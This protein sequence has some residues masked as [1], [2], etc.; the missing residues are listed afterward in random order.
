MYFS[1]FLDKKNRTNL[2]SRFYFGKYKWP[3]GSLG[4]VGVSQSE[5][6]SVIGQVWFK[7]A[8]IQPVTASE[9]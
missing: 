3:I 8:L 2:R 4:S 9:S 7:N 1:Y 5:L 6:G